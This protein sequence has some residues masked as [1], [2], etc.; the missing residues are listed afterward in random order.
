MNTNTLYCI[1]LTAEQQ[2]FLTDHQ[3][4]IDRNGCLYHLIRMAST[5]EVPYQKK[6]F[7]ARLHIGQVAASEVELAALWK[8]NRKT[9]RRFIS[10]LNEL[11]IMTSETN[12][13]TSIHSLHCLAG[14]IVDGVTIRNPSYHKLAAKG[15]VQSTEGTNGAYGQ[16]NV[17]N[18]TVVQ[19]D[20]VPHEQMP[21]ELIEKIAQEE[22]KA[23]EAM[24]C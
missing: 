5:N 3:A 11:G 18:T 2:T 10:R 19:S 12:N 15:C 8:C 13:R 14:W 21:P 6:G 20:V 17:D 24:K 4:G 16:I 7:Q 22:Q 23:Q 1:V 9:V